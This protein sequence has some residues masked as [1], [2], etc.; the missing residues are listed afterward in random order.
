MLTVI[1]NNCSDFIRYNVHV[2]TNKSLAMGCL[3]CTLISNVFTKWSE[4][5]P[6]YIY[7]LKGYLSL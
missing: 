5:F 3:R 2:V 1:V 6:I 4:C 7:F